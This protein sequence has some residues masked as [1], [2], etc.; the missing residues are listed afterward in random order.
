MYQL[1][2]WSRKHA[3]FHRSLKSLR[4]T[5]HRDRLV[6]CNGKVE[7]APYCGWEMFPSERQ[8]E[9]SLFHLHQR[10]STS[11]PSRP[12]YVFLKIISL[13]TPHLFSKIKIFPLNK[14]QPLLPYSSPLGEA[15]IP[16]TEDRVVIPRRVLLQA[17]REAP[18]CKAIVSSV[19]CLLFFFWIASRLQSFT[20]SAILLSRFPCSKKHPRSASI[21]GA[22]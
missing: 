14:T 13:S 3:I 8:A 12:I 2:T 22:P 5:L 10:A 9:F 18:G 20:L 11:Q 17:L 16:E 7:P 15:C 6:F 19:F 1:S 4:K 21:S